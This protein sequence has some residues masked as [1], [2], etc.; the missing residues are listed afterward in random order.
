M[1]LE[2][3]KLTSDSSDKDVQDAIS[4]SI[5]K[6]MQ[7]G[8]KTQKECAAMAYSLARKSSGKELGKNSQGG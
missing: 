8:G 1:P 5:Q 7:E 4:L 2:A 6:C 3:E